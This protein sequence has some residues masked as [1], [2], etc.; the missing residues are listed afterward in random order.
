MTDRKRDEAMLHAA[1]ERG[2]NAYWAAD[3]PAAARIAR[4]IGRKL[5]AKIRTAAVADAAC[6]VVIDRGAETA[7][8]LAAAMAGPLARVIAAL[9]QKPTN[10]DG[11]K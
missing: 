1:L 10:H 6:R 7:E 11:R 9:E 5:I 3:T 4:Q 8:E 2:W